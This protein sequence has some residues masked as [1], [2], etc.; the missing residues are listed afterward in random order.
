MSFVGIGDTE[1][2]KA[3]KRPREGSTMQMS[4]D[5]QSGVQGPQQDHGGWKEEWQR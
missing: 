2:N 4:S 5:I 1:G 3:E